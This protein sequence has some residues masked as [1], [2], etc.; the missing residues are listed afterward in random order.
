MKTLKLSV[1]VAILFFVSGCELDYLDQFKKGIPT[2]NLTGQ[3]ELPGYTNQL[4][5]ITPVGQQNVANNGSLSIEGLK[6]DNFQALFAQSV[7]SGKAVAIGLYDPVQKRVVVND[8]STV[9]S[10]SFFHPYMIFSGYD[11]RKSYI[12]EIKKHPDF[13]DLLDKYNQNLTNNPDKIFEVEDNS[14]FFQKLSTMMKETF[15]T[16]GQK[17]QLTGST[18]VNNKAP[19]IEDAPGGKVK[20]LNDRNVFY[21]G[22]LYDKSGTLIKSFPV[23]TES[24][25][26]S[27]KLG[28]PP[29][30]QSGT[31][32]TQM[33]IGDGDFDLILSKGFDFSKMN[34]PNDPVGKGTAMNVAQC[35][36]NVLEIIMGYQVKPK[37]DEFA[38]KITVPT[39]TGFKITDGITRNKPGKALEGILELIEKNDDEVAEWMFGTAKTA[40]TVDY[41]GKAA[42]LMK[43]VSFIFQV[44]GFEDE[45]SPFIGE[46]VGAP[47]MVKYSMAQS[48]GIIISLNETKPPVASFTVSPASGV[49]GTRFTFDA[50][51][52]ADPV[53][54]I[55]LLQ[56]RWDFTSRNQFTEW[57]SNPL[58]SY[59][60]TES[61]SF[62]VVL[63][64]KN[65]ANLTNRV[66]KRVN[67]GGGAGSASHV[68]VFKN[69]NPWNSDA[70]I[71]V[72]E[73]LGFRAGAGTNTYEILNSTQMA[74][75]SL[76]PGQDLVIIQNDQNQTFYNDYAANQAKFASF[77]NLGGSMFWEA[78]DEGWASGSIQDANITLPG[79]IKYHYKLDNF[80]YV[81]DPQLPLVAGLPIK[82]D[83]NYASHEYFS[84]LA[85]G[86]TVYLNNSDGNPTLIEFIYGGGWIIMAAQ[87]LEHQYDRV[88][89][90]PDMEQL[91]PR[92]VAYFTG[93]ALGGALPVNPNPVPSTL[94]SHTGQ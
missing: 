73:S 59:S 74:S 69:N 89:N 2:T 54:P 20:F 27:A 43:K 40:A 61:G 39:E 72:L 8:T 35:M 70:L 62:S 76:I 82:M 34:D 30:I 86:T 47:D 85:E 7:A 48:G 38:S 91:L 22:G 67:V 25:P 4:S 3:V 87:P 64:V 21:G 88:Y 51:A 92:I 36:V 29:Q 94:A 58:I 49:V 9:I 10:V 50:S 65:T 90:N 77:V 5:V 14:E 33:D 93:K 16:M 84:N 37:L 1:I 17:N 78:C 55:S 66:S 80:N 83:H 79:N 53:F 45:K 42:G 12:E 28:W 71:R 41:I 68:K 11:Q 15:Q 6:S 24:T 44:L 46:M 57:S 56:F 60:Y 23:E 13:G 75:A 52:S 32:E 18:P 26:I 63:E 31:K 81:V 19:W